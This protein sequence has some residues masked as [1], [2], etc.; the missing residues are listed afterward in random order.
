MKQITYV[1]TR[2]K[3]IRATASQAI[4]QGICPDGGLFLPEEM[5]K[6]EKSLSE[7]SALNYRELAYEVLRLF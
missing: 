1:G 7:L 3:S 2:D 6:M 4:L 5:P